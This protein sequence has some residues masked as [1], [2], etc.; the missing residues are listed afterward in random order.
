MGNEDCLFLNVFTKVLPTDKTFDTPRPVMVWLHGGAFKAGSGNFPLTGPDFLI[1]EDVVVVT[2]NYRLGA[3]GFLCVN[4]NARG[5]MGLHDQILALKWVK[6]NI[7]AFGGDPAKVT[8]FGFS[9]GAVS[10]D[11]L[12]L[13]EAAQG[14]FRSAI[15]QSG[16][17]LAPWSFV[18]NP[19]LQALRLGRDL[20]FKGE[21]TEDLVE[22]LRKVPTRSLVEMSETIDTPDDERNA[23]SINFTPCIEDIYENNSDNSTETNEAIIKEAPIKTLMSGNYKN[24]PYISGFVAD[25]AI[26][27][28]KSR[29]NAFVVYILET[30]INL[31][32]IF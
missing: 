9:A 23:L 25:E 29:F 11:I 32:Q 3:L 17:A 13:S 1:N 31:F 15:A 26:L 6:R 24:I 30:C 12:M 5:N 8:I 18:Q 10:V 28:F 19:K 20:G 21:S 22:F 7:G 2:I 4:E 27:V 16:S 14:L